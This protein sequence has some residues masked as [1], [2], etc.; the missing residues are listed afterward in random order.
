[1][2]HPLRT[3]A[4]RLWEV[5]DNAPMAQMGRQLRDVELLTRGLEL[6]WHARAQI[7]AQSASVRTPRRRRPG[8]VSPPAFSQ[9]PSLNSEKHL[10]GSRQVQ[11]LQR[12]CPSLLP[13]PFPVASAL[14]VR[15]NETH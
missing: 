11:A 13:E 7:R 15:V 1:M 10:L 12:I 4:A 6:R 14:S 8:V 5:G 3:S 9:P 2:Y